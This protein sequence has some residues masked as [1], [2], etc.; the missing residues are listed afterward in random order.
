MYREE[1]KVQA[2]IDSLIE[3]YE[4]DG[5]PDFLMEVVK[6]EELKI[7]VG[8]IERLDKIIMGTRFCVR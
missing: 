1:F 2:R 7:Y 5:N 3:A 4:G 8:E 6:L